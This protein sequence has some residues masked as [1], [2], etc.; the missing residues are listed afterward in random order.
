VCLSVEAG[1]TTPPVP[2]EISLRGNIMTKNRKPGLIAALVCFWAISVPRSSCAQPTDPHVSG[3]YTGVESYQEYVGPIGSVGPPTTLVASGSG[4]PA[5]LSLGGDLISGSFGLSITPESSTEPGD[6]FDSGDGGYGYFSIGSHESSGS[7]RW[8]GA[9]WV[10]YGDFDATYESLMPD[11]QIT[12]GLSASA[13]INSGG[14]QPDG[15]PQQFNFQFATVPTVPE[16]SALVMGAIAVLI[17]VP[18]L[19][20]RRIRAGSRLKLS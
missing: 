17:L 2:S 16:P 7:G 13:Y 6:L 4:I 9:S 5:T 18:I 10:T 11:G 14:Y 12:G 15:Q 1:Q 20:F 19:W 8:Y 3:T